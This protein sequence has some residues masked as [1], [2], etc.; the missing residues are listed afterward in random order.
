MTQK[1]PLRYIGTVRVINATST[2]SFTNPT[3]AQSPYNINLGVSSG[4]ATNINVNETWRLSFRIYFRALSN[5]NND[6]N[7]YG[8]YPYIYSDNSSSWDRSGFYYQTT[9]TTSNTTVNGWNTSP[10]Y[11]YSG[12][13]F[14]SP[15]QGS[16]WQYS[17]AVN[18]ATNSLANCDAQFDHGFIDYNF[19][20]NHKPCGNI[21]SFSVRPNGSDTA[22]N[23]SIAINDNTS[24]GGGPS[25]GNGGPY[26]LH[27]YNGQNW[28]P[29]S[30]FVCYAWD[31][32]DI[33]E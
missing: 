19:G 5:G 28:A 12:A 13:N 27:I 18:T 26:N 25:G 21:N 15:W 1:T 32:K 30:V 7:S 29:G 17:Y 10:S 22:S 23:A 6:I 31:S 9:G 11:T 20:A 16:T 24:V 8:S 14:G 4:N 33:N 2:V 3:A